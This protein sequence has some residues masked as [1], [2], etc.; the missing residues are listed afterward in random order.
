MASGHVPDERSWPQGT[1]PDAAQRRRLLGTGLV[2]M[3]ASRLQRPGTVGRFGQAA[4]EVSFLVPGK[5][6]MRGP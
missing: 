4:D 6:P 2:S 3:A 1:F 5:A